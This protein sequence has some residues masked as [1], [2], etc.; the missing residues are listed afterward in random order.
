VNRAVHVD[1]DLTIE[2]DGRPVRL[3]GR[4]PDLTLH[5]GH[6]LAVARRLRIGAPDVGIRSAVAGTARAL[7]DAGLRVDVASGPIVLA[8]VGSGRHSR[9]ARVLIGDAPVAPGPVPAAIV[10]AV[11]VGTAALA[12]RRRGNRPAAVDHT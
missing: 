1:A 12:R 5:T 8:R 10:A 11:A 3:T 4:G 9:A 6:P 2:V 7:A